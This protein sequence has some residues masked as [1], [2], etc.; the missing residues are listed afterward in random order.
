VTCF[1][2]HPGGPG[3]CADQVCPALIAASDTHL[4]DREAMNVFFVPLL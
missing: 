3:E 1:L 2:G 4:S